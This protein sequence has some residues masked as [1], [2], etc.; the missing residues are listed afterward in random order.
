MTDKSFTYNTG[1]ANYRG[2]SPGKL[3]VD[4]STLITL[5]KADLSGAKLDLLF[6]TGRDVVILSTIATEATDLRFA[7]GRTINDWIT[8]NHNRLIIDNH[9]ANLPFV[10]NSNNGE[11]T[12]N[13]YVTREGGDI[14]VVTE[15]LVWMNGL[16]PDVPAARDL[17]GSITIGFRSNMHFRQGV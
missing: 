14:R 4:A 1:F 8:R 11:R 12:I 3:I 5:A 15:D 2:S 7:D 9:P 13:A 16:L 6:R 17:P 10:P